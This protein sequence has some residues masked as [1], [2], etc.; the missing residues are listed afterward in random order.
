MPLSLPKALMMATPL[1]ELNGVLERKKKKKRTNVKS[2]N[3]VKWEL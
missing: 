1:F 2:K 3:I